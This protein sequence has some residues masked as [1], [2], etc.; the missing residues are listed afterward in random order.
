MNAEM[1]SSNATMKRGRR[2][3]EPTRPFSRSLGT[4]ARLTP[5]DDHDYQVPFKF[6]GKID[7]LT[8]ALDQPKL[9][10]ERRLAERGRR[11]RCC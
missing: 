7:K 6:T 9:T 10:P 8:V 5:V 2:A 1:P 3:R 11:L 4:R